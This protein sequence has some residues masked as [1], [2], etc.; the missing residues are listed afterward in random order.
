M[1]NNE[2]QVHPLGW[3]FAYNHI[4]VYITLLLLLGHCF[5]AYQ[6]GCI[7]ITPVLNWNQSL[8]DFTGT[9]ANTIIYANTHFLDFRKSSSFNVRISLKTVAT[10]DLYYALQSTNHECL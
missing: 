5:L 4:V 6:R 2:V 7:F 9:R 1:I 3:I 10:G 8:Q